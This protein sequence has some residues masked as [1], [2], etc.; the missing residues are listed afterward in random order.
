MP[1]GTLWLLPSTLGEAQPRDSIAAGVLERIRGLRY[2]IAE[3]PKTARAFLKAA[4]HP[5]PL[6]A[7]H[8]ERLGPQRALLDALLEPIENGADAGL[9]SEAGSPAVADPGAA[10]VRLA[11]RRGVHVVPLPGPSSIVLALMA[12]G[13]EGQRFAFHGY[14]PVR[15]PDRARAIRRAEE[16]SRANRETAIFIEAPYRNAALLQALLAACREDTWLCL[17]TDLTLKGESVTTR[18]VSDWRPPLPDINRRPTVFLLL[19]E[20][21]APR[22]RAERVP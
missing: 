18:R 12:S 14:L 21:P 3:E 9:L 10:L 5:G 11:H 2:F 19:A 13:L 1:G 6:A 4:G 22:Q 16:R 8:I 17:A 20:Q 15:D 7:L